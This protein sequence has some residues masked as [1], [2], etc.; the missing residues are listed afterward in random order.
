MTRDL[1]QRADQGERLE[2]VPARSPTTATDVVGI[3]PDEVR[4]ERQV[5]L[6]ALEQLHQVGPT[7]E[8]R[9]AA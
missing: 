5:E 1:A 9:R 7:L 2:A 3:D 6:S 4:E 8:G